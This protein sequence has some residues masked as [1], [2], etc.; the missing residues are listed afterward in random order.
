[1]SLLTLGSYP[2][3]QVT[4]KT[5]VSIDSIPITSSHICAR[6]TPSIEISCSISLRDSMH[7]DFELANLPTQISRQIN[8]Q[9]Y[10]DDASGGA[11]SHIPEDKCRQ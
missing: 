1:M 4:I 10:D 3:S 7:D 11:P 8:M 2:S 9:T 5:K 6:L